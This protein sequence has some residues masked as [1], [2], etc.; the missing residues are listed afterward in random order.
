MKLMTATVED[1]ATGER[2]DTMPTPIYDGCE[3]AFRAR[4]EG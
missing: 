2:A 1:S 3:E 4:A